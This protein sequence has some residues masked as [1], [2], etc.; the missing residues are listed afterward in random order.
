MYLSYFTHKNFT[1]LRITIRPH[2]PS[3]TSLPRTGYRQKISKQIYSQNYGCWGHIPTPYTNQGETWRGRVDISPLLV[4]GVAPAGQDTA[5]LT[6]FWI[7]GPLTPPCHQ[8]GQSWRVKVNTWCTLL[9]YNEKLQVNWY[10]LSPLV[11][12]K[13]CKFDQTLGFVGYYPTLHLSGTNVVCK[14]RPELHVDLF[15]IC[16]IWKPQIWPYVQVQPQQ[17]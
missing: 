2:T 11:V 1:L 7:F 3:V 10:T 6:T 17:S 8:S 4:Q 13:N 9:L 16:I 14:S 12:Q 15:I 5:N